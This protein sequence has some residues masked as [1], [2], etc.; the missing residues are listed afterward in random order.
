MSSTIPRRLIG[1][2]L[3]GLGGIAPQPGFAQGVNPMPPLGQGRVVMSEALR[4]TA[5][6]RGH[7]FTLRGVLNLNPDQIDLWTAFEAGVYKFDAQEQG[8]TRDFCAA[9]KIRNQDTDPVFA[10]RRAAALSA[11][12]QQRARDLEAL[13]ADTAPLRESLTLTQQN[14]YFAIGRYLFRA[15]ILPPNTSLETGV[16]LTCVPQPT[17]GIVQQG[18]SLRLRE[19]PAIDRSPKPPVPETRPGAIPL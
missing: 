6:I 18:P 16:P 17:P 5:E 8:F 9:S 13:E 14:G 15:L 2:A 11:L 7:L 4:R 10:A 3:L 1:F 19:G 12:F